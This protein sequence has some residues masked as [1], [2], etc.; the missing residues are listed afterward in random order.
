MIHA[1]HFDPGISQEIAHR[2]V[3]IGVIAVDID[4][5]VSI[6]GGFNDPPIPFFAGSQRNF[7]DLPLVDGILGMRTENNEKA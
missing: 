1:G 2:V 4:L 5:I 3:E 6:R 7:G